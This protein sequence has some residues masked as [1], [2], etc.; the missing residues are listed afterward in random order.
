MNG[1]SSSSSNQSA[2]ASSQD[3]GREGAE[4]FAPLDLGVEDGLHVG[5]ARIA[6]DRAVAERARAPLHAALKP[7]DDL[8]VGDRRARCA[9]RARPRPRSSRPCSPAPAISRAARCEQRGDVAVRR[10]AGPNRR[11]PS[12]SERAPPSLCQTREG[13]ADRAAGIARRRLHVDA[14]ERRHPPDL[15]VGDRVHGAAAGEREIGRARGARAA[16]RADGRT[17]PRTSPAPSGRCRGGAPRAARPAARRGP[18]S[19]LERRREQV[20]ELRA[21]RPSHW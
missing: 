19:C 9:G 11:G 3:R 21:S 7:A 12:R 17:P 10:T 8:A 1:T 16:R 15:A 18:S 14:P 6:D 2:T 13:R 20:A 5:A 4:R